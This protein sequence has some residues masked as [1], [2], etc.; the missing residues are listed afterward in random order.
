MQY[1][2]AISDLGKK[3]ILQ[4]LILIPANTWNSAGLDAI[5]IYLQEAFPGLDL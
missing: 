4:D 1:D 3:D 2:G 5:I